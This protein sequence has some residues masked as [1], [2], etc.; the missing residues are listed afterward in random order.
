MNRFLFSTCLLGISFSVFAQS[1][2]P[3]GKGSYAASPPSEA[4][5][6]RKGDKAA[7]MDAWPIAIDPSVAD[8]PVPTNQWWTNLITRPFTGT[9]W[10]Y[11]LA[12]RPEP[13]GVRVFFPIDWNEGGNDMLLEHPLAIRADSGIGLVRP[14][15]LITDFE[16][17]SYPDGWSTTGEAFG[18][19]PSTGPVEGQSPVE[20]YA[21]KSFANSHH[22]GDRSVGDLTSSP[23]KIERKRIQFL[24]GGGK[25]DESLGVRLLV[26]GSTVRQAVG[27]DRERPVTASWDVE[28]FQ[29][30]EAR[31]Q[32][33]DEATGGWGHVMADQFVQTDRDAPPPDAGGDETTTFRARDCKALRWGDWSLTLRMTGDKSEGE[34]LDVTLGRGM[35]YCWVDFHEAAAVIETFRD[36]SF[37]T[38]DG[39]E[40]IFPLN[41]DRVIVSF[42]DR[43]FVVFAPPG[44]VILR[45]GPRLRFQFSG[46]LRRLTV[47]PLLD[48]LN[49]E[50]LAAAA[51]TPPLDTRISWTYDPESAAIQTQWN[52]TLDGEGKSM[53]QG[54]L[55]HHYREGKSDTVFDGPVFETPRGKMRCASGTNFQFQF[56]FQGILPALPAPKTGDGFDAARMTG[57]LKAFTEKWKYGGDTY[58]GGKDLLRAGQCLDIATTTGQTAIAEDLRVKLHDA[59]ADWFTYTPGESEH[60][61]A[62]YNRWKALIGFRDSYGSFQFTDNHFHYGYFTMAS[63]LLAR[64][65]PEFL[66]AFGP[67]ATLVAKQYANWDRNDREFPFLRTFDI[68]EG[69]SNA[70]GFGGGNG[71][72]QESSSEAMQSWAG[73]FLLGS[74]LGDNSMRDTG[75]MGF[76]MERAATM[77]YWFNYSAWKE[78]PEASNW[79]PAYKHSVGGIIQSAGQAFA[80]YFSG[81]PAWIYGIQWLPVSTVLDYLAIDPAFSKWLY[82]Q[83]WEERA[84][85]L[86]GHN[87]RRQKEA[88]DRNQTF[89]AEENT[90]ASIGPALGNV[91][92]GYQLQFDPAGM[93]AELDPLWASRDPVGID[94]NGATINYYLAH[95]NLSLGP[96]QWD[97]SASPP[98]AAVYKNPA[99]GALTFVA[100]NYSDKPVVVTFKNKGVDSGTLQVPAGKLI[101]SGTLVPRTGT[102]P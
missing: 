60:Y 53:V 3:I 54:W 80:T 26:D 57:Y 83:M 66:P 41:S 33:F 36:A 84:A 34:F 73:L 49:P 69:H 72:N 96:R 52:L 12:V 10:P 94:P 76:A 92:L 29:G 47:S 32:I 61:F 59:L 68:W 13:S 27:I 93:L 8:L 50:S 16:G 28:E 30:K 40:A 6:K 5:E 43:K 55:P 100:L 78:G 102:P 87:T 86:P 9:V 89:K 99:P 85:W 22:Q 23:F 77:Q 65:D 11:P 91:L 74:A 17:K 98:T 88:T 37:E 35:P 64:H 14:D 67:M 15:L 45:D 7:S 44:S 101:S 25:N 62:R 48:G 51:M 97:W 1:P 90:M 56:P 20:G 75:A 39:R 2:V 38:P 81:D 63:A 82:E 71:N 18:D 31:I 58:W 21:G 70:G 95:A 19:G 4:D 79:P 46:A 42:P 24:V